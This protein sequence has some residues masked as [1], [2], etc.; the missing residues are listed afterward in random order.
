MSL[1]KSYGLLIIFMTTTLLAKT[2]LCISLGTACASA[3]NLRSLGLRQEAYPFDW[4]ISPLDGLCA[5]IQDDFKYWLTDLTIRPNNQ[6][7]IDRYGIHFVHDL[8]TIATPNIDAANI[9]FVGNNDLISNWEST[10]PDVR[11]KY[12]KRIARFKQACLGK[13]KVYF[14]RAE[15]MTQEDSIRLRDCLKNKYPNLDFALIVSSLS[16]EQWNIPGVRHFYSNV[17]NDYATWGRALAGFFPEFRSIARK[18]SNKKKSAI[19][20]LH[21][22]LTTQKPNGIK[23]IPALNNLNLVHST[24]FLSNCCFDF[25]MLLIGHKKLFKKG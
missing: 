22:P 18:L 8:P 5:A 25:K 7:V 21:W 24:S 13:E 12:D 15:Y 19:S 2:P 11:K 14:F 10:L 3:M 17:W 16:Q 20:L 4:V 6:G 23:N 1:K 9:D